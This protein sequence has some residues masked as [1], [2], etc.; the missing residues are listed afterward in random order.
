MGF[1][2][3][4][5]QWT[6]IGKKAGSTSQQ[7]RLPSGVVREEAREVKVLGVW[8][9]AEMKW[10]K[11]IETKTAKGRRMANLIRRLGKGGRGMGINHMRTMY[12]ATARATMEYGAGAW[13]K[14]QK[15]YSD[16]FDKVHEQT[17]R[18]MGGHFRSGPGGAVLCEARCVPTA[19]QLDYRN[20]QRF[21]NAI[22]SGEKTIVR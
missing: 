19:V 10:K 7:W 3:E 4:K 14:G 17:F 8:I 5:F 22:A 2:D 12:L 20:A 15:T 21:M 11:Q 16:A 6:R 18:K 13:W 1:E 9:D